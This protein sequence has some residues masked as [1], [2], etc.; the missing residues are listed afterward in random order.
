MPANVV[1]SILRAAPDAITT[2]RRNKVL[3][4]MRKGGKH[5][6]QAVDLMT[7]VHEVLDE[8]IKDAFTLCFNEWVARGHSLYAHILTMPFR[9]EELRQ[10]VEDEPEGFG[11]TGISDISEQYM[12]SAEAL[13]DYAKVC[14]AFRLA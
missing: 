9:C 12:S 4:R 10:I 1:S 5:V 7:S 2:Y 6:F 3:E 11:T 13:L 8:D 14:P